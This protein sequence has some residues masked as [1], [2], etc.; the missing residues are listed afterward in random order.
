MQRIRHLINDE[1]Q[2][3]NDATFSLELPET[4]FLHSLFIR[5]RATNGATSG[6]GVS[7][8]DIAD[9][10][11]VVGDGDERYFTLQPREIEKWYEC[12]NGKGLDMFETDAL[13]VDQYVIFPVQFG[14]DTFDPQYFLPL[15]RI[16]NPRLEV[17]YSPNIA[18]D[19]GFTTGTVDI[20]VV[21]LWSPP[22]DN[23]TYGGT[24][25]TRT[26][27]SFTSVASG[28]EATNIDIMDP[29]RAVGVYVYEAGIADGVD[30]TAIEL[31]ANN[32]E[33]NLLSLD[34]D[35]FIQ[36]NR[37]LFGA[38]IVHNFRTLVQNN[39][40]MNVRL[41]GI[42]QW[43]LALL[44]TPSV[45]ADT[46]L[47]YRIDAIAGDQVTFAGAE[48][49]ITA[50]AE[51]FTDHATDNPIYLS[52]EGDSPSY[53]GLIPYFHNDEGTGYL[54]PALFDKLRLLLSQGAAGAAVRISL[55]YLKQIR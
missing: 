14:R 37:H 6:L 1:N 42:K 7:P 10:V 17:A 12:L 21:G 50:G 34:W 47:V 24:L 40:T 22:S 9:E 2:A 32:G 33:Y 4:G 44:E 8:L 3:S 43:S 49:D 46:F 15:A 23:L 16:R 27:K 28:D 26:I 53:F 19:G 11:R 41:S 25:I 54:N 20:D 38:R 13:S 35:N 29:I 18:A 39:D 45:A 52:V 51:T 55:Q 31:E 48:A 36:L 5:I 30:V